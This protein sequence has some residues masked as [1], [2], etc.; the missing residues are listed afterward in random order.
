M[1]RNLLLLVAALLIVLV[2]S[3]FYLRAPDVAPFMMAV[4]R[5]QVGNPR[6]VLP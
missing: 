3:E 4:I 2:P 5:C 1:R 6:A